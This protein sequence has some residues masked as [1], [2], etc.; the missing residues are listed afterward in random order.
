MEI[1]PAENTKVDHKDRR[2]S[3]NHNMTDKW[4]E[5]A[6]EYMTSIKKTKK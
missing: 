5:A 3:R 2:Y 6:V 1:K 4:K